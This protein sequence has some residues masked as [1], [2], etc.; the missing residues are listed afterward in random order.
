[1]TRKG[2]SYGLAL[3]NSFAMTVSGFVTFTPQFVANDLDLGWTMHDTRY[4]QFICTFFGV[5]C[6]LDLLL[7]WFFYREYVEL[8]TGWVH[9]S[10]YLWLMWYVH[11]HHITTSFLIFCVEELPTF[12]LALGNV[13]PP[14]RTNYLFGGCF[15]ITRLGWHAVMLVKFLLHRGD[16]ELTLWPLVAATFALHVHWFVGF[17]GQQLRRIRKSKQKDFT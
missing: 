14:F 7:G 5:Y 17:V 10:A 16:T 1:M 2:M 6:V 11:Y 12:L 15:F 13:Y 8:L 9:H 4:G 3:V